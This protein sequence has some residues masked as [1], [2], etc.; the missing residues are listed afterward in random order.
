M[1]VPSFSDVESLKD[2]T[3]LNTSTVWA[4][5][6]AGSIE[7]VRVKLDM[8]ASFIDS[9]DYTAERRERHG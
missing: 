7:Y 6:K 8:V 5:E 4:D 9:Q 2:G 3:C 1:R